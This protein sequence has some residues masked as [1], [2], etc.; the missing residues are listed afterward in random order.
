MIRFGW[1]SSFLVLVA[2]F[3]HTVLLANNRP[4][5]I[6]AK[7]LVPMKFHAAAYKMR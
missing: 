5:V 4:L 6:N 1:L 2:N 7:Y 3:V